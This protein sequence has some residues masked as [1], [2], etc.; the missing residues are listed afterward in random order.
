[1]E[2]SKI[3]YPLI[4]IGIVDDHQVYTDVLQS[5]LT[6]FNEFKI[7]FCINSGKLLMQELNRY[8][9]DILLLD[10]KM[11]DIDGITL[12]EQVKKRYSGVRVVMV[13]FHENPNVILKCFHSGASGYFQK[14]S[15]LDELQIAI[16]TVYQRGHHFTHDTASA[17]Y[18]NFMAQSVNQDF[19]NTGMNF[20]EK[21]KKL[22][23]YYALDY[24]S[25]T[26]AKKLFVS[27]DSLATYRKRLMKKTGRK[28]LHGLVAFALKHNLIILP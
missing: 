26:I 7:L 15:S 8:K 24:D 25:K 19:I 16:R 2:K 14:N 5:T 11:K 13:S 27:E 17:L 4:N 28:T 3:S 1:M 6:N 23:L 9:T 18:R 22:L 12:L 21:E 10:I 20:T